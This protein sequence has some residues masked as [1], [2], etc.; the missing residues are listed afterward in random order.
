MTFFIL[1]FIA[2]R[3]LTAAPGVLVLRD[4]DEPDGGPRPPG[5]LVA[6]PLS[7]VSGSM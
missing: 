1:S 7:E 5:P 6:E 3:G 4:V 2:G